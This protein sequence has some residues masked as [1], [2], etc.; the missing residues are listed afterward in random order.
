MPWGF[1]AFVM[2]SSIKMSI[3]TKIP[4]FSIVLS[5]QHDFGLL[6]GGERSSSL[7]PGSLQSLLQHPDLSA[8]GS[9]EASTRR[10]SQ[11][12]QW[13]TAHFA[14]PRVRWQERDHLGV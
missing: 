12:G 14:Y 11:A 8:G 6:Q 2:Q 13:T 3:L 1:A 4:L 5:R 9:T 7:L 10:C